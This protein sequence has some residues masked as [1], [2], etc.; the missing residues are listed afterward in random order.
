MSAGVGK[1]DGVGNVVAGPCDDVVVGIVASFLTACGCLRRR[2]RLGVLL[3]TVIG[4]SVD[5]EGKEEGEMETG[6]VESRICCR[7]GEKLW[8]IFRRL[9]KL[10]RAPPTTVGESLRLQSS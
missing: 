10:W 8:F 5:V 7:V 6:R 1:G 4:A 3:G 2:P 9:M